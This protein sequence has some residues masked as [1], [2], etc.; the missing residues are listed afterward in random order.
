MS[1]GPD[2]IYSCGDTL[3][4]KQS[5]FIYVSN[6]SKKPITIPMGQVISQGQN[7]WTG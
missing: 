2:N 4:S 1:G 6:F 5:P 3:V 7:P